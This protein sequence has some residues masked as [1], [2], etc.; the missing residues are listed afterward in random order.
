MVI[1]SDV[2][3]AFGRGGVLDETLG[4]WS[5]RG[6]LLHLHIRREPL[7]QLQAAFGQRLSRW[8]VHVQDETH[9]RRV[10]GT[11]QAASRRAEQAHPTRLAI[12]RN[13]NHE[14]RTPLNAI[15]GFSELIGKP[16]A[17]TADAATMQGLGAEIH[18]A[19]RHLPQ[20][21][22]G[23]L[24]LTRSESGSQHPD[25][26]L[27]DL[28]KCVR[29]CRA[30]CAPEF[31]RKAIALSYVPPAHGAMHGAGRCPH[32]APG[33]GQPAGQRCRS[34]G[35]SLG[36]PGAPGPAPA[37]PGAASPCAARWLTISV[38]WVPGRTS[39]SG[40]SSSAW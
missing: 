14:M 34:P 28:A 13:L 21:I 2:I 4:A 16:R 10:N 25:R 29:E 8:L 9:A 5:P 22:D 36:C 35:R 23:M 17:T 31:D 32:A 7:P 1:P 11:P 20:V 15:L 38:K 12:M 27:F 37:P 33:A 18:A 6:G 39:A 26:V 3:A 19:G 24:D 40:R 30:M